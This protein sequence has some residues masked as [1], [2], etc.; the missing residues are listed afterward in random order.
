MWNFSE[1]CRVA[2]RYGK[3]RERYLTIL[4][5]EPGKYVKWHEKSVIRRGCENLSDSCRLAGIYG[6]R[7]E[8]N[9]NIRYVARSRE[10]WQVA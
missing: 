8:M 1:S 10:L 9:L 7:G 2:G 3:R 6:K 4:C 5:E